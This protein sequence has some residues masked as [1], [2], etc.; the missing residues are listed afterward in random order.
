MM[1]DGHAFKINPDSTLT[2]RGQV[3]PLAGARAT[4]AE[5]RRGIPLLSRRTVHTLTVE[6]PGF[7][8]SGHV[9]IL[10]PRFRNQGRIMRRLAGEIN[11]RGYVYPI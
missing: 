11:S 8:V 2:Y 1:V 3:Y 7:H 4:C 5:T 9:R 6:G 10:F